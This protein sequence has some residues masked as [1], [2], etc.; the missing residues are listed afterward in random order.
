MGE[1]KVLVGKVTLPRKIHVPNTEKDAAKL[2]KEIGEIA[3]KKKKNSQDLEREINRLKQKARFQNLLL[4]I[5]LKFRLSALMSYLEFCIHQQ[6]F[7]CPHGSMG[8]RQCQT[9]PDELDE[10]YI[11]YIVKGLQ[12]THLLITKE[13]LNKQALLNDPHTLHTLIQLQALPQHE[14]FVKPHDCEDITY[15]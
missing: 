12:L 15:R 5:G 13:S 10:A 2:I 1:C 6:E 11:I 9:L 8:L 14:F 7:H 3:N 4:D